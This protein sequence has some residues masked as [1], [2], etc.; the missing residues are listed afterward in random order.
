MMACY[1]RVSTRRQKV[2]SQKADILRRP[3]ERPS[4]LEELAEHGKAQA[5][6]AMFVLDQQP[7]SRENRPVFD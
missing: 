3:W 5:R 1:C 2:D 7:F 4:V 6:G